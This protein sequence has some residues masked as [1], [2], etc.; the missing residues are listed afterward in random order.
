MIAPNAVEAL[1]MTFDSKMHRLENEI[2][3]DVVRR[4]KIN[5]EI[6]RS[7]DWQIYRLKEL[8]TAQ[9]TIDRLISNA[10]GFEQ[11]E[12]LYQDIIESGYAWDESIYDETGIEQMQFKDNTPLQDYIRVIAEQTQNSMQNLSNSLGFATRDSNGNVT[13]NSVARFYQNTLDNAIN[14]IANGV[15]SYNQALKKAVNEMTNS[16]LRSVDYESGVSSRIDVAT[17]RAVM[18]GYNQIVGKMNDMTAKELNTDM[19]EVSWHM[20]ARPSHQEWQGRWFNRQGLEQICGL[21]TVT[22]LLGINCYH[23]YAPVI[24][25]ISKPT[26]TEEELQ[27]T[28]RRRE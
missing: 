12:M 2:M 9:S 15:F 18:T 22:G 14:G 24:E 16:G 11:L 10:F 21:G 4:I 17:R 1:S 19:F 13:F 8:G 20:G 27:K 25:G 26:Y 5:G 3:L 6:T 28:S 23:S 7:A